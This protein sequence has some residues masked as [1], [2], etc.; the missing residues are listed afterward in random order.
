MFGDTGTRDE[1]VDGPHVA[2][3][4]IKVS[5]GVSPKSIPVPRAG[6]VPDVPLR[7][8]RRTENDWPAM[9][10]SKADCRPDK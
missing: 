7:I 4:T 1:A 3:G 5:S 8:G 10:Q 9:S 2:A 6:I